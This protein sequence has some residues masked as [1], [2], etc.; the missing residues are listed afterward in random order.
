MSIMYIVR[1]E[2]VED[3]DIRSCEM[4]SDPP[5]LEADVLPLDHRHQF[6]RFSR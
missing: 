3:A 4:N 2:E 1:V 5:D 6:F